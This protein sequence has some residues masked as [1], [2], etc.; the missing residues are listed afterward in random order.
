MSLSVVYANCGNT[1]DS[2]NLA[3]EC[4]P[5]VSQCGAGTWADTGKRVDYKRTNILV[6][7]CESN[8]KVAC[9][10]KCSK[11]Y[12]SCTTPLPDAEKY[13]ACNSTLEKC[14]DNCSPE[15]KC[16]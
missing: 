13:A 7:V 16:Y 1:E 5:C 12:F 8:S 2:F 9:I 11:E 3:N 6:L 15:R 4:T 14:E 10:K